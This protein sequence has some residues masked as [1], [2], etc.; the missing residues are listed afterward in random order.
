MIIKSFT[1]DISSHLLFSFEPLFL[2]RFD[3]FACEDKCEGRVSVLTYL[4]LDL[5]QR[6]QLASE[7]GFK[8]RRFDLLPYCGPISDRSNSR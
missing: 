8:P 4:F 6:I 5:Q 2:N 7:R 3:R 1:F